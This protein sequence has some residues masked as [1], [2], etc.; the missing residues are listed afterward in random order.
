M[1]FR[2]IWL[3]SL[4]FFFGSMLGRMSA[5]YWTTSVAAVG[6]II[7]PLGTIIRKEQNAHAIREKA[8][9]GTGDFE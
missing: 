3:L 5:S 4:G 2:T 1:V 9:F 6:M 7:G 8:K